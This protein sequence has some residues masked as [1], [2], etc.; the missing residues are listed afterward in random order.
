MICCEIC[1]AAG[2]DDICVETGKRINWDVYGITV[3][4]DCPE[5]KQSDYE[6]NKIGKEQSNDRVG[7]SND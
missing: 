4:P 6:T 5:K 7:D 2:E 3:M 1:K